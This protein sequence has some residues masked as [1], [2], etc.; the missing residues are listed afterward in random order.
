[1]AL[2]DF[3]DPAADAALAAHISPTGA[4]V[5]GCLNRTKDLAVGH[6]LVWDDYFLLAA[7][8]GLRQ[9]LATTSL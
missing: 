6:E 5:D 7:A 2:W 4:L 1:M 3:D 9:G 8:L